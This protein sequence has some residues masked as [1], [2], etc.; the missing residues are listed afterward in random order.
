MP[1]KIL[2]EEIIQLS[3]DIYARTKNWQY[4]STKTYYLLNIQLTENEKEAIKKE[5][6][7]TINEM[8]YQ[9]KNLFQSVNRNNI[10]NRFCKKLAVAKYF[11]Q[12]TISFP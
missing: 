8:F 12:N 11:D 3:K 10:Q 6:N 2:D 4:I 9:D 5:V 7:Q 1:E